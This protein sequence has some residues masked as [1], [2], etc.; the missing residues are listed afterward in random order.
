MKSFLMDQDKKQVGT[1]FRCSKHIPFYESG[2]L[3]LTRTDSTPTPS[4]AYCGEGV[5]LIVRPVRKMIPNMPTKVRYLPTK[6]PNEI[7]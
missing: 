6:L 2:I 5:K 3:I 1:I 4:A 7:P